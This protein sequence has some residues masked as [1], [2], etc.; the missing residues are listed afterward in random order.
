MRLRCSRSTSVVSALIGCWIPWLQPLA[1]AP[2]PDGIRHPAGPVVPVAGLQGEVYLLRGF[3][4]VFSRGLD[5]IAGSLGADGV[6]AHV[7]SHVQWR[8]VLRDIL[9]DR[10]RL[11]PRPIVLVGHSL[12]AN[13]AIQVAEE[14]KKRRISVQYLVTLAATEPDPVPSNVMR[15]DNF[16]FRTKGWGEPLVPAAGFSGSLRNLDFSNAGGVGHFNIDKQPAIQHELLSN[17]EHY[18]RSGG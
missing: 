13:A 15:A 9:D 12:G 16:Y 5:Q 14:L 11:G 8:M 17:I 1:A 2:L 18:V 3:A 4:D 7:V 10:E 6:E